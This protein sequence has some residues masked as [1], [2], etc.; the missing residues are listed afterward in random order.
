M[1]FTKFRSVRVTVTVA[2]G[3]TNWQT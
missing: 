3:Q 1:K 2:D